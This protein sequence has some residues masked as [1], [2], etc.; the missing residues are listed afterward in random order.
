VKRSLIIYLCIFVFM[1]S[2]AGC[3]LSGRETPQNT[4]KTSYPVET[5]DPGQATEDPVQA[6]EDLGQQI[7]ENEGI[8]V[9]TV[10]SKKSESLSKVNNRFA[11]SI[12]KELNREDADRNIFIS[13]LSISSALGM[14]LNG[15]ESSTKEAMETTL[16]YEGMMRDE[17]NSGY[18][19]LLERLKTL[20]EKIKLNISNSIWMRDSFPVKRQFIDLNR[21]AYSAEIEFLDFNSPDA[22]DT[23]NNWIDDA[24][25]GLISKMIEPPIDP[26]TIM[27][28]IN[29]IYFKGIWTTQFDPEK[30]FDGTFHT[31]AGGNQSARMM[32]R[33]GETEYLDGENYKAIRL[34]YGNGKTAM[35]CILPDEGVDINT[36]IS[37]FTEEKWESLKK[38][39][40]PVH[41]L[42]IQIP[43]F[44]MEYGIKELNGTLTA[45]G[46]GEAFQPEVADFSGIADDVWISAVLHKAVIEVNE[47]GSEAAAATAVEMRTTSV[48]EPVTFIA[49]RP[50]LF[51][52]ADDEEGT[53]L[54]MGKLVSL[55]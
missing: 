37:E 5:E 16:G 12:F 43:K 24:T 25:E 50:F 26:R 29:A 2:S 19:Y 1:L 27:Y 13:P 22:A 7:T 3:T 34:S 15:A 41:D 9:S 52:I 11:W 51:I 46:M 47:E 21:D 20:D 55:Q 44:K 42:I 28:L 14:A 10:S 35:Y 53:V 33:K 48:A 49:D 39:L 6:T 54:F 18:K 4:E 40:L 32:D 36:F 31:Y 38:G 45:L 23:I 30:T 17:I 8:D